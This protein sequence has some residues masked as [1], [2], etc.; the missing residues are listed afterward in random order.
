MSWE[1][2]TTDGFGDL[3]NFVFMFVTYKENLYVFSGSYLGIQVYRS[4]DGV[5]WIPANEPG[6][7]DPGNY[8]VMRDGAMFVY[9]GAL[10]V[11][12]AGPAGILKLVDP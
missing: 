4:K 2:V 10:Y 11:S 1:P 8:F 12:P 7:G 3:N 6:W 5:N 9:K